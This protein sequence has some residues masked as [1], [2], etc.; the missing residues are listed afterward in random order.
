M[1]LGALFLALTLLQLVTR[2]RCVSRSR[3]ATVARWRRKTRIWA[4]VTE[5]ENGS[6]RIATHFPAASGAR[7]TAR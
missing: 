2:R 5:T 7:I 6:E 1:R 3:M 4:F